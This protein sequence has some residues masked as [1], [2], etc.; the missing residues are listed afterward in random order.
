M[1]LNLQKKHSLNVSTPEN[2]RHVFSHIG[3]GSFNNCPTYLSEFFI[4]NPIIFRRE[5]EKLKRY[6]YS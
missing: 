4:L 2:N 5:Y 3:A 6:S 1:H